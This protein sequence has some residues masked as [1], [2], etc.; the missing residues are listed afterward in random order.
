MPTEKEYYQKS[1]QMYEMSKAFYN[2]QENRLVYVKNSSNSYDNEYFKYFNSACLSSATKVARIKLR[3]AEYMQCSHYLESWVLNSKEKGQLISLLNAPYSRDA[4]ITNWQQ[5]IV[6]YNDDFFNI[7][8][9]ET[10][11]NT[12]NKDAFPQALSIAMEMPNYKEL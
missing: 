1:N 3:S 8:P 6:T 9:E 5:I 2:T 10:I 7:D 12:Y 4:R 11:S